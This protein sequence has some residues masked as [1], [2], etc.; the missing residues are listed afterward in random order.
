MK[1]PIVRCLK[2]VK[3]PL[4]DKYKIRRDFDFPKTI[5]VS[6]NCG[7][8]FNTTGDITLDPKQI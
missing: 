1:R 5:R 7:C 6:E 4:C 3:C 2:T 8:E